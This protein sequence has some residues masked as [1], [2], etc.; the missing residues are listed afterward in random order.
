MLLFVVAQHKLETCEYAN[1]F[2]YF[3]Y[4]YESRIPYLNKQ[5]AC[6]AQCLQKRNTFFNCPVTT[7][8][9]SMNSDFSEKQ[10]QNQFV[11]ILLKVQKAEVKAVALTVQE[12]G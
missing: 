2:S 8:D 5:L 7:E 3:K 1:T 4:G 6:S 9:I 10:K 12:A 11:D